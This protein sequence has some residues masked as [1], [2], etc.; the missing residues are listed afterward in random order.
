[1]SGFAYGDGYVGETVVVIVT[2]RNVGEKKSLRFLGRRQVY[3]ETC[4]ATLAYSIAN[5][6][7]CVFLREPAPSK[8]LPSTFVWST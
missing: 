2:R 1:M 4:Q 7:A 8:A 3:R 5:S 6:K